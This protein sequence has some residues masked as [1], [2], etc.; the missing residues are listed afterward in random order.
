MTKCIMAALL[1]SLAS[2]ASTARADSTT[3]CRTDSAG[4]RI[5]VERDRETREKCVTTC[6]VDSGGHQVCHEVCR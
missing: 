1:A 5:C 3:T 2:L 4:N 6:R